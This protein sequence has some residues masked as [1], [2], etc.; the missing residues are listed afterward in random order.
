MRQRL[1]TTD[2]FLGILAAACANCDISLTFSVKNKSKINSFWG[3]KKCAS[4]LQTQCRKTESW[5]WQRGG[6]WERTGTRFY[7]A[8]QQWQLPY[9]MQVVCDGAM[10]FSVIGASNDIMW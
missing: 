6:C 10:L 2:N 8:D 5:W 4:N 1:Q 9:A 7:T 3:E